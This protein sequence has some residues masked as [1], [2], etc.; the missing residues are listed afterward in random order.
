MIAAP[1]PMTDYETFLAKL[2]EN[3]NIL[4]ERESRHGGEAPLSLLNQIAD[5]RRAIELTRQAM[6]GDLSR[7]DWQ[8]ALRPLLLAVPAQRGDS[9]LRDELVAAIGALI[10]NAS[11]AAD[12]ARAARNVEQ[13]L[14]A[15]AIVAFGQ[16]LRAR[17]AAGAADRGPYRGLLAYG[18]GD[19]GI[20]FGRQQAI[21]EFKRRL[22]RGPLTILHAESGAGK[23]S[24]I[25]AGIAPA[26]LSAGHLPL[27]LRPLNANPAAALKQALLPNLRHTPGL[28]AAPLRDFL[29]QAGGILGPQKT[30]Y[31]F[32]DQFEE[33]FTLLHKAER[34]KFIAELAACLA[35]PGL[36]VRWTLALRTEYFGHLANFRPHIRNPFE[37]D[38]RL[39]RLTPLQAREVAEKPAARFG[40][41]GR[42]EPLLRGGG[43][44]R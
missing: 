21:T 12:S 8:R 26:L 23:S 2:A 17:A 4:R 1:L 22:Q 11:A 24:L 19:A 34:A 3:L 5:H 14:L 37:N 40:L 44:P 13:E 28:T 20:F 38:Y 42:S 16:Q 9:A 32:L 15:Q 36:N 6:A 10:H 43:G 29:R 30:I 35:D 39:N 7:D 18:L 33:F 31:I 27:Y 25:Q 41:P